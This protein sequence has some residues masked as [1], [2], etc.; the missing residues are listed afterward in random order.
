L[1]GEPIER[2]ADT[3]YGVT[4]EQSMDLPGGERGVGAAED[5]QHIAVEGRGDYLQRA[6]QVHDPTPDDSR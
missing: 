6:A 2:L 1:S 3:V 5:K 4:L